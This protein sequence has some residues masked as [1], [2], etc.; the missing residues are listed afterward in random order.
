MSLGGVFGGKAVPLGFVAVRR[1]ATGSD[2]F[3]QRPRD[4]LGAF[5]LYPLADLQFELFC[6][7]CRRLKTLQLIQEGQAVFGS[8]LLVVPIKGAQILYVIHV[9]KRFSPM[10]ANTFLY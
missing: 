4:F 6:R 1:S 3:C 9:K 5:A 7:C 10:P 8:Y 2:P